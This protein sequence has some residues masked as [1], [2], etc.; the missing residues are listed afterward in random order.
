MVKLFTDEEMR[1]ARTRAAFVETEPYEHPLV[2]AFTFPA[3]LASATS[4]ETLLA[5]HFPMPAGEELFSYWSACV[6]GEI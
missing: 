3:Y 1:R 6:Q 4:R 2:R 5:V